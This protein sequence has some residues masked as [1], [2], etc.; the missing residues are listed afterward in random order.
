MNMPGDVYDYFLTLDENEM[1]WVKE[2][3]TET[4]AVQIKEEIAEAI[5]HGEAEREG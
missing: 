1:K 4:P 2:W 3:L 5:E